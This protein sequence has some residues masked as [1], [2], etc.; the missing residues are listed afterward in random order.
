MERSF[1]SHQRTHRDSTALN[2]NSTALRKFALDNSDDRNHQEQQHAIESYL[3]WGNGR[4]DIA[5]ESRRSHLRKTR[6][7]KALQ[8]A[9]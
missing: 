6:S 1:I 8:N 4:R 9:A 5:I 7:R 2:A 3:A